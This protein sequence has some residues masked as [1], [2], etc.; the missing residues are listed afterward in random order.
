VLSENPRS[1]RWFCEEVHVHEPA[2]R[3]WMRRRFPGVGDVDNVIQEAM[4]R[5]WQAR[6]AP[7]MASPRAF[8]FTTARN[9]AVDQ[10]RHQEV[11]SIAAGSN[12]DDYWDEARVETPAAATAHNQELE[13]L[14]QA[15]RSLPVR[16]RQV[17][18]LRKIYGLSQKQIAMRL[19][20]SEH[21]VET[22]V[23]NG[24]RRCIE[25]F[26]RLGLP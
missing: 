12:I 1:D 24:M 16:C 17:L 22:Q 15:I 9:L 4:S 26:A 8:L 14:H 20:I 25:F 7:S 13:L 11:A 23:A 10:L 2:L 21:T 19:G 6:T 5:A 3:A 18:L